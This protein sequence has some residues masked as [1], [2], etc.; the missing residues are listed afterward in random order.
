MYTGTLFHAWSVFLNLFIYPV[1]MSRLCQLLLLILKSES[2][3]RHV[4]FIMDGNRTFAKRHKM[5][6]SDGHSLGAHTL[7]Q[8]SLIFLVQ[9][10]FD[11]SIY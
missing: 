1:V 10:L 6:P 7:Q 2:V 5:P 3:P 4:G 8:V 9:P 11:S